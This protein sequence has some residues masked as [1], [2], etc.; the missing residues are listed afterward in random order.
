MRQ[1]SDRAGIA[2]AWVDIVAH[3]SIKEVI[4]RDGRLVE[5]E[6]HYLHMFFSSGDSSC[7][8]QVLSGYRYVVY[9]TASCGSFGLG[10]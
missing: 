1:R 5:A 6:G 9:R 3:H 10:L 2:M 8:D 7:E 4:Q